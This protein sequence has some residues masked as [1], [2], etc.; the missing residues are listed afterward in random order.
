MGIYYKTIFRKDI[1][2][3]NDIVI[4][5]SI[6]EELERHRGYIIKEELLRYCGDLINESDITENSRVIEFL[7]TTYNINDTD[8]INCILTIR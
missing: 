4:G 3:N 5:G 2:N 1:N 8:S 6:I 7:I